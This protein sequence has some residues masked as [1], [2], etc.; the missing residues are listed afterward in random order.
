MIEG[1]EE[2]AKQ[3]A[4]EIKHVNASAEIEDES[5]ND[6]NEPD[7]DNVSIFFFCEQSLFLVFSLYRKTQKVVTTVNN[8]NHQFW[9]KSVISC[10]K[11]IR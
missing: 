10:S 1:D 9:I 11:F 3:L 2:E 7:I 6:E 8:Q 4:E 5:D